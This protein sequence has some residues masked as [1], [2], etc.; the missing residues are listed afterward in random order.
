QAADKLRELFKSR[1][2]LVVYAAMVR[3]GHKLQQVLI[4]GQVLRQEP[5]VENRLPLVGTPVFLEA[6]S[7]GEVEFASDQRL[8]APG[9]RLVVEL[10]RAIE[11]PMVGQRHG[12]HPELGR[13]LDQAVDAA[14]AIQ[15]AVVRM[16]MK[17][18]EVFI[19][20]RQA[21]K[22]IRPVGVGKSFSGG[23]RSSSG[24]GTMLGVVRSHPFQREEKRRAFLHRAPRPN[25][26]AMLPDD[27]VN[28]GETDPGAF[29]RAGAV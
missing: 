12:A 4:T 1:Q 25:P 29:E 20:S 16:D 10:D 9:L 22:A 24:R 5:E 19:G 11:I 28:G 23:M 3:I 6:R 14:A 27:A 15:Q 21:A 13:A 26:S 18:N 8:D 17:V 7:F 2:R